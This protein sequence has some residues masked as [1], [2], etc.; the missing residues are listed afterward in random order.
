MWVRNPPRAPKNMNENI[1]EKIKVL[2]PTYK[3]YGP[4]PRK[5][6]KRLQLVLCDVVNGKT[7]TKLFAKFLLEIK[8][9]RILSKEETVDHIDGNC[10]NDILANVQLLSRSDN[11]AKSVKRLVFNECSCVWCGKVFTPTRGNLDKRKTGPFCSRSCSGK[12]GKS[13]QVGGGLI[14]SKKSTKEY[15]TLEQ[16]VVD[17]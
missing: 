12:Y 10:L 3:I 11:S 15:Y 1:K 13:V 16:K 5:K 4:Y 8:L 14:D 2:Y 17:K 9:G 6:D 7:I